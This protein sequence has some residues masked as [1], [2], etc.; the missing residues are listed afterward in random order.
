[1]RRAVRAAD[2]AQAVYNVRMMDDVVA[3]SVAPRR[4]NTTLIAL[5]TAAALLLAAFGVY[6]VMS[7]G[8]ACRRREL[9]IRAA[10]GATSRD[11][12]RLVGREMAVVVATSL[13]VG[14]AAAWALA[15]VLGALLFE[16]QP[17]DP[18]AFVVAPLVL[19]LAA[20]LATLMPVRRAGRVSPMEVMRAE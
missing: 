2:P 12:A 17:H 5:F 14:L 4:T 1:M 10:L 15:R 18:G 20:M 3:R 11:I 19:A 6:A 7:Y 9:G 16:V 13:L 8:V